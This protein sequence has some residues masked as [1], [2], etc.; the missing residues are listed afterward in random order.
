MRRDAFIRFSAGNDHRVRFTMAKE[1]NRA[2]FDI[3]MPM[4]SVSARDFLAKFKIDAAVFG[5]ISEEGETVGVFGE[6]METENVRLGLN[7][8]S[9]RKPQIKG[10]FVPGKDCILQSFRA[11]FSVVGQFS[12]TNI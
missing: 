6:G 10:I 2:E 1:L 11:P 8:L 9:L 7:S 3:T 5:P 4:G 12:Q